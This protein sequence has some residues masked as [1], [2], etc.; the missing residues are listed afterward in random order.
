[1]E[2]IGRHRDDELSARQI[3]PRADGRS[4]QGFPE[5]NSQ[6][7]PNDTDG[8]RLSNSTAA[9][10]VHVQAHEKGE[11]Y[12]DTD[13]GRAPGA[14]LKGIDNGEAETGESDDDDEEDGDGGCGPGDWSDFLAGDLSQ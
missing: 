10:S 8:C 2:P 6:H 9:E 11:R 4:R 7:Q 3:E 12:R 13:R 1:D 5:H 14:L